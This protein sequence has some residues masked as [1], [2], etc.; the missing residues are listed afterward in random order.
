MITQR[1]RQIIAELES[2]PEGGSV[3]QS[4]SVVMSPYDSG[5]KRV[6]DVMSLLSVQ[7]IS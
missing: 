2:T 4:V 3:K 7:I 6:G 1:G 5:Q